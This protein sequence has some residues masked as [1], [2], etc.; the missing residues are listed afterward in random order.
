MHVFGGFLGAGKT[1]FIRAAAD[2]LTERGERVAIITN[3]QAEG[4]VDTTLCADRAPVFEVAGGCF[5]CRYGELERAL[6]SAKAGGA[7]VVF[8]EA[9]GSCTDLVAT[10]LSPL[11]ARSADV[12]VAP[13][14]VV[15]DPLRLSDALEGGGSSDLA[16]LFRKQIEEA[17]IVLLSR[18]DLDPP[19]VRAKVAELSPDAVVVPVSGEDG[20]GIEAWYGAEP[21]SPS[22]TLDI[23]YERYA[24]AEAE[25]GWANAE[26]T[27]SSED[28]FAPKVILEAFL[29]AFAGEPV[30]HVKLVST[31]PEGGYGALVGGRGEPRTHTTKLPQ[32]VARLCARINAR[33]ARKPEDV[34]D[35]V[36]RAV[37]AAARAAGVARAGAGP[38]PSGAAPIHVVWDRL[39]CFSPAAPVPTYRH[40]IRCCAPEVGACCAA[41]YDRPD[42]RLL[43]GESFH[44]GGTALTRRV[45]DEMGLETGARLLDVACG[46]GESLVALRNSHGIVGVGLDESVVA[47]AALDDGAA[48]GAVHGLVHEAQPG[49]V[50]DTSLHHGDAHA[51]PFPDDGFDAVLCECALSTFGAPALALSEMARVL[52]GG[53]RL[54]VTD[55]VVNGSL[56]ASLA[57]WDEL[58]T[59]LPGARTLASYRGLIEAAGFEITASWEEPAAITEILGRIK[60]NLVGLALAASAGG[61]GAGGTAGRGGLGVEGGGQ[62]SAFGPGDMR[63]DVRAARSALREAGEAVEEGVLSYGVFLAKKVASAHAGDP[64]DPC[65]T[66]PEKSA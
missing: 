66:P 26:V 65:T 30:A 28:A 15:V 34:E 20:S 6:E 45:A 8:A 5:C 21:S 42:V 36:V 18:A 49:P 13:L 56:P 19:D 31:S 1:T 22:R 10:V 4:L 53:G 3:D 52:R 50:D 60:R 57:A 41:F 55:V 61:L 17:D 23:D 40:R 32:S 64:V 35:S 44:P 54:A 47:A 9:V 25:L 33:I 38:T 58:G 48:D 24:R 46:T 11:C 14:S 29:N 62:G 37:E 63:V 43:L 7:T 2:Y 51:L 12:Q 27:F 16:Y 59:C 39:Q